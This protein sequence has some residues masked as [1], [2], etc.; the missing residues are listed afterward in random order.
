[1]GI[2]AAIAGVTGIGSGIRGGVKMKDAKDT[3]NLAKSAH[4]AN[5]K[6]YEEKNNTAVELMDNIGKKELKVLNS[7][8]TF[9]DI[10]EQIKNRPQFNDIS[11]GDVV[12]EKVDFQEIE[13]VSINAGIALGGLGGAAVGYSLSGA[14]ATNVTLATLGGGAL[15][16]GGGGMALGSTI[17]GGA[18]LGVGLLVGG[19]IFN[20][21]GSKLSS[22]A[23]EAYAEMKKAEKDIDIIC[24]YLDELIKYG[25]RFL[26]AL[27]SVNKVYKKEFAKLWDL[28]KT[29]NKTNYFE[30]SEEEKM[31]VENCVLLVGLLYEITKTELVLQTDRE[32][33]IINA[34]D[35][36]SVA[37]K[38]KKVTESLKTAA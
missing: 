10:F 6:R 1:M 9:S 38:S 21:T 3:M 31:I 28:V 22:K 16:A 35:I 8:K 36:N 26:E 27:N 4:E 32:I 17:L 19:I 20:V 12:I 37:I 29:D 7:F 5:L 23:E 34:Y 24:N 11:K 18:T 30:Y 2:G 25:N 33:N 15:S 13:K 14:A